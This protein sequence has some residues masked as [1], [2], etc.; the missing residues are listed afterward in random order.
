M[1]KKTVIS[2]LVAA[3]LAVGLAANA[4]AGGEEFHLDEPG[5]C[6]NAAW[7]YSEY[8]NTYAVRSHPDGNRWFY[9]IHRGSQNGPLPV[10]GNEYH[11]DNWV[12]CQA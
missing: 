10:P 8:S 6:G 12:S 11:S 5:M 2:I 3:G 7:A 4:S 1:L 9:K